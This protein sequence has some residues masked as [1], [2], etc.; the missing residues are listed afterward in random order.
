MGLGFRPKIWPKKDMD[1]QFMLS[2]TLQGV[3][4]MPNGED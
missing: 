2:L 1:E 4:Q 3:W